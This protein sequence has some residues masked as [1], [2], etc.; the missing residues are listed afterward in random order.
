MKMAGSRMNKRFCLIGI[1]L[2]LATCYGW[3]RLLLLT[4]SYDTLPR[5]AAHPVRFS[6]KLPQESEW[7]EAQCFGK[8]DEKLSISTLEDTIGRWQIALHPDCVKAFH[9]FTTMYSI[10]R[11]S[12]H[13]VIPETF[14]TKV[15]KWLGNDEELLK[16]VK[17]QYITTIF[18]RYTHES[19]VFNPLR[20]KRPGVS[21][22]GEDLD[23]YIEELIGST[24]NCDFCDFKFK[25]A[26]DTFGRIESEH[27]V[28]AS[29][30][31]K[32]D[33]YHALI[34]L[35]NHHPFKFSEEQF[36]DMFDVAMKW[37]LKVHSTD[38]QYEYP[39]LM[40][41]TLPKASAS[42][43]H[44]HA[45]ASVSSERHYGKDSFSPKSHKGVWCDLCNSFYTWAPS[46]KELRL[47]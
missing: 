35:K 7:Y 3:I 33:A 39:Q 4:F 6:L 8:I 43:I 2:L 44:P 30:T 24:Q 10:S 18:N 26:E 38:K 9:K 31:F 16:E 23:R 14:Q 13:V 46:Y 25:T 36:L 34:I 12:G 37:F 47:I 19:S 42:Q 11:R 20:A 41:D 17:L 1:T 28:T 29:N 5:K 27:A 32:Y 40:W 15:L 21:D 22:P 45:Q